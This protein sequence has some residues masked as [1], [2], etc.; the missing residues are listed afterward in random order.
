MAIRW[1]LKKHGRPSIDQCPESFLDELAVRMQTQAYTVGEQ[2]VPVGSYGKHLIIVLSGAMTV[3]RDPPTD[4]TDNSGAESPSSPLR[5][6]P[7]ASRDD[8]NDAQVNATDKEPIVGFA[9]TL[10]SNAYQ[11]VRQQASGWSAQAD[12]YC[13]VAAIDRRSLVRCSPCPAARRAPPPAAPPPPAAE[14]RRVVGAVLR[15]GLARR[16]GPDDRARALPLQPRR[17]QA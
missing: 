10:T 4:P 17:R 14:R 12:S 3:L 1:N 13:D 9:A 2:V 15:E 6:A 16:A 8:S 11:F 7:D 5:T